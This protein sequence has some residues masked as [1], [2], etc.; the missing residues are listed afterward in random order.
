[1]VDTPL[2][3]PST[4]PWEVSA[5]Q[6]LDGPCIIVFRP[7]GKLK[8]ETQFYGPYADYLAAYDALDT[9]PALGINGAGPEYA[10]CKYI[11]GLRPTH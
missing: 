4:P 11:S 10:G 3:D 1:M 5:S 9:V 2:P 6:A 8:C 7:H